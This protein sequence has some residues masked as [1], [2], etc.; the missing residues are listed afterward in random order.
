MVSFVIPQAESI[1]RMGSASGKPVNQVWTA[2]KECLHTRNVSAVDQQA[3][4]IGQWKNAI[5]IGVDG[6]RVHHP[7]H[8]QSNVIM[9]WFFFKAIQLALP[10]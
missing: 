1:S 7:H 3:I 5:S 4:A 10:P 8:P 6:S 9:G 2:Y